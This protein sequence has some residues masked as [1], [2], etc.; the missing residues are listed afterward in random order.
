MSYLT[1]DINIQESIIS[2]KLS[3]H[4]VKD[5]CSTFNIG[6]YTLYKIL[7]MNGKMP[8]PSEISEGKGSER[9]V[10]H[11]QVSPNN[12]LAQEHPASTWYL[13]SDRHDKI[14]HKCLRCNNVFLARDR[15]G[16]TKFC[17]KDCK[18]LFRTEQNST[19]L[20]CDNCGKEFRLKN[21]Q[22][23]SYIRCQ[24]CSKLKLRSPSSKMSRLLGEWLSLEFKIEKE[25]QFDWLFDKPK[26]R[27]KLDYFLTDFN[28][29]I[30]YDGEQHF[31]PSFTSKWESVDK[32]QR[33]DRLKDVM[34][35]KRGI[36][37]IRFKYDEKL[38]KE[39]VLMKIYAELQEN[40]LVEVEDKKPLR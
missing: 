28:I 22:A 35:S 23:M 12:N 27:L 37:I 17:S 32:V 29:G 7:H 16:R 38:N 26:G 34:C 25:K 6:V 33:R 3:G 5:I 13:D 31:R 1:Y 20:V 36:K 30:E 39:T 15:G 8:T 21:S 40:K 9:R 24:V 2:M 11:R 14:E 18:N 4:K 10:E 19:T